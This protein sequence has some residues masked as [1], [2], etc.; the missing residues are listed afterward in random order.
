MKSRVGDR[1]WLENLEREMRMANEAFEAEVARTRASNPEWHAEDARQDVRGKQLADAEGILESFRQDV[2][3]RVLDLAARLPVPAL[4]LLG[5]EHRSIV[6]AEARRRLEATIPSGCR[7]AVADAG[8]T[9]HRDR[10]A[11]YVALVLDWIGPAGTS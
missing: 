3:T 1:P 4:Y 11:E 7:V 2:G 9:V 5:D 10:L 6:P 8:H